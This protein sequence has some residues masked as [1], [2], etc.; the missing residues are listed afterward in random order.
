MQGNGL[1]IVF[2]D[3]PLP[4]ATLLGITR[5]Y[6]Q[7]ETIFIFPPDRR[8]AYPARVFTVDEELPFAGH[9]VLGAAAILHHQSFPADREADIR[10][11]LGERLVPI[12]SRREGSRYRATMNQGCPSF[13]GTAGNA[14]R[15]EIA[16][17]LNLRE[18]DLDETLPIETVSTGL[19]YLLVPVRSGLAECGIVRAGFEAFLGG[20]GAKF[21]Y[22]FDSAALEC[23]TW[24]NLAHAEDA[25]TG[26][27]AGPLCAYL[28]KHGRRS[29]DE[30]IRILQGR[31]AG[32]PSVITGRVAGGDGFG[33]VFVSGSVALFAS[34][35][36][37][38]GI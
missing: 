18:R 13:L 1:T 8:G 37:F 24:D 10:L 32:R 31:F 11:A 25:A 22:I 12:H 35:E 2:P 30:E 7:S 27:A 36:L 14:R 20:F 19:P 6:K 5:E 21:A 38:A 15:G 34:G 3:R 33:D 16:A 29:R 4:D 28:V 9:P 17:A 23:R 26:S